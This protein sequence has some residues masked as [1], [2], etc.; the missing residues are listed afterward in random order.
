MALDKVIIGSRIK[1]IR[2]DIFEESR[3]QFG[4]RCNLTERHIGQIERGDFLISLQSLDLIASATGLDVDYI[5]YGKTE[6]NKGEAVCCWKEK[7]LH[8]RM[9]EKKERF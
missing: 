3:N 5:L 6:E 9:T 1:K 7:T 8:L 2:E 4:K